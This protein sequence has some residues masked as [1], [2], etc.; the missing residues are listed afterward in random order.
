MTQVYEPERLRAA[1]FST[2]PRSSPPFFDEATANDENADPT[3]GVPPGWQT[4]RDEQDRLVYFNRSTGKMESS[5]DD[6]FKK[7]RSSEKRKKEN[8]ITSSDDSPPGQSGNFWEDDGRVWSPRAPGP[9]RP[10]QQSP[11]PDAAVSSGVPFIVTPRER[12]TRVPGVVDL[13]SSCEDRV[14]DDEE[15]VLDGGLL[16]RT[17]DFDYVQHRGSD[18]GRDDDE[19]DHNDDDNDDNQSSDNDRSADLLS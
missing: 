2:P 19:S 16:P 18:G 1:A 17:E 7:P 15:T 11:R 10:R 5:L 3:S 14:S 6:L 13:V 8:G 9:K 12:V 4:F